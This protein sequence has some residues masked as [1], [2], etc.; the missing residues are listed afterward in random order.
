MAAAFTPSSRSTLSLTGTSIAFFL[1]GVRQLTS[2]AP[3]A[4]ASCTGALWLPALALAMAAAWRAAA[5]T[6]SA[7]SSLV[8]A[9]PQAPSTMTRTPTPE[10]SVLT[11][12]CTLS[13]RVVMNW[14]R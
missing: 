6:L 2:P 3:G 7:A 14:R 13:S 8:A 4:G 1:I 10:D 11:T 12:F 5:A 9:K